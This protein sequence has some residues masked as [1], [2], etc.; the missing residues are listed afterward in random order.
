M[1][2][3]G[4]PILLTDPKSYR[5]DSRIATVTLPSAALPNTDIAIETAWHFTVP[6][7]DTTR[8]GERMGR[9]GNYLYQIAQWYPQVAM[10][11]DLRGWDLDQ[12]LGYGEFYNQFGSFDVRI[13][14]VRL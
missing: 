13:T 11:D 4:A 8:R 2:I 5:V 12:Y 14:D 10:Y 1:S 6:N 9:F 3:N 7:V